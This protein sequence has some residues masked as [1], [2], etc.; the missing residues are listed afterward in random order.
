MWTFTALI[1]YSLSLL[2]FQPGNTRSGYKTLTLIAAKQLPYI[3]QTRREG[4]EEGT[5]V[6]SRLKLN[7][8]EV[9]EVLFYV[10]F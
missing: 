3:T 8:A 6:S 9:E 2:L 7:A 4:E 10:L 5:R 1:H